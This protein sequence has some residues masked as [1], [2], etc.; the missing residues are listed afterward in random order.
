[1]YL[2]GAP[3]Y[4][5][6][7]GMIMNYMDPNTYTSSGY[8]ALDGAGD[9]GS[10]YWTATSYII[11]GYMDTAVFSYYWWGNYI[12]GSPEYNW[13]RGTGLSVRCLAR[14]QW[15]IDRTNS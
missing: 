4:F 6:R 10:A 2:T 13:G 11:S 15:E 12:Q 9:T 3:F 5:S 1:M 14:P 8:G 7:P